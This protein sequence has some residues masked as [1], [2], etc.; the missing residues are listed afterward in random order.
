MKHNIIEKN[1][2]ELVEMPVLKKQIH[3]DDDD[4]EFENFYSRE[5]LIDFLNCL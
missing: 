2:F 4:D 5:Q 1:P 3:L